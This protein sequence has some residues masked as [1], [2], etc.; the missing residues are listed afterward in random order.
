[1]IEVFGGETPN[2]Y[3]VL[4]ALAELDVPYKRTPVDITKG[5]QFT[6]A[7]LKI[8]PNN[9]VPAILDHDPV[10][11]GKPLSIFESGAI[12]VYLAERYGQFLPQEPRKRAE[13][14]QWV[15][16]Q[17]AGQ[18]PMLGQLGHFKN[19]APEK[20]PYA[21]SRYTAEADRLY[22]VLNTHL[23]G[24][25][26]ISDGYSIADIACWP[27]IYFHK[28]HA[29]NLA[30]YP[31]LERWFHAI[32]ERPAIA[33]AIGSGAPPQPLHLSDAERDILFPKKED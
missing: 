14:I 19:Y 22:R 33:R 21:I 1:M 30:D 31:D 28:H 20:I 26:Y 27:W 25:A 32:K 16:W 7:F 13:V 12:L 5:E 4:I 8:S 11:G 23:S 18:G 3:K 6:P 2:V 10:D 15:M 29:I 9:R 17:M 24:R